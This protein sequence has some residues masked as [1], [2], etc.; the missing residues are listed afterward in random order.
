MLWHQKV[1]LYSLVDNLDESL[2][3]DNSMIFPL[4]FKVFFEKQQVRF[5]ELAQCFFFLRFL[6]FKVFFEMQQVRFNE[7]AQ[8]HAGLLLFYAISDFILTDRRQVRFNE[9]AQC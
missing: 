4:S 6:S 5:N 3:S 1:C 7:L 8:Y 2:E 9:L